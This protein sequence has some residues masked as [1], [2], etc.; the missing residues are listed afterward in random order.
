MLHLLQMGPSKELST[1][2]L[3]IQ[4]PWQLSL[5]EL[6]PA[7]SG[8]NIVTSSLDSFSLYISTVQSGPSA[9]T[10]L[11]PHHHLK[12]SYP[13]FAYF[14]SSPSAPSPPLHASGCL[15]TP[16]LPLF[17]SNSLRVLQ[18]NAWGFRARSTKL[19]H[20]L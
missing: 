14:V 10:A 16:L 4:N 11:L 5:L 20:F 17:P 1:L 6:P 15:S 12:T 19:L 9:N 3:Q 18:W 7:S 13:N 8:D 2:L